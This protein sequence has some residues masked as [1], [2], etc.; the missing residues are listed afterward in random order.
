[1]EMNYISELSQH[2]EGLKKK[3]EPLECYSTSSI[4]KPPDH[5]STRAAYSQ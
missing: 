3:E 1:M 4:A 5:C 2:F